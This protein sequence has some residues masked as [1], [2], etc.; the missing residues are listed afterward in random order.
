MTEIPY[1]YQCPSCSSMVTFTS[2]HITVQVCACGTVLNRMA[3]GAIIPRPFPVIA[4]K[5]SVIAPGTTGQWKGK[6]FTVSGRFRIWTAETVFNYWTIIFQDETAAYLMEGYGMYA[7]L[8]PVATPPELAQDAIKQLQPGSKKLL[9]KDEY[10]LLRKDQC[11]K[12]DV[13]GSLFIPE[14]NSTFTT[15]DFSSP[16]G[17]VLHIIEYWSKVQPAFEVYYT[18]FTS[19][20]L[21]QTR[22]YENPGWQFKCTCG[23]NIHVATFPYAQ[24]C[25]CRNCG[26]RYVYE[27]YLEFVRQGKNNTHVQPAI[28][29]G[30]TGIIKGI[31]YKVIGFIV[32]E[33]RNQYMSQW[34]EYTLFNE[35]EGYAFLSEYDGHWIYLREQGKTPVP[36]NMN[37][38][39]FSYDG[40][41]FD[42]FN[43]Y[44]YNIV[45]ARGEFPGNA[46]NDGKVKCWEFISPPVMWVREASPNEGVVWFKGWHVDAD[47]LKKALGDAII[48]PTQVGV[49]AIQPNGYIDLMILLRNTLIAIGVLILLHLAI[50][51]GSTERQLFLN[52]FYFPDSS[53][54]STAVINDIHLE[55]E[56]SNVMLDFSAPV[57]NSWMELEATLV[58]TKTGTEYSVSKG[59][60][61]YTGV[62]DGYRWSEGNQNASF[63]INEVPRGDYTMK[64]E[65]TREMT[66]YPFKSYTISAHY[67]V[68]NTRNLF[69]CIGLLLLWPI[70]KYFSTYYSERQRWSNSPYSTFITSEE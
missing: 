18:D 15:F 49:G 28:A 17:Q 38:S 26:N 70:F 8:L 30:A 63:Y 6:T 40:Y 53:K 29:L 59:V 21:E 27:N 68:P 37:T 12:W 61:Y 20:V 7:I 39:G 5:A 34:R 54:V 43:S 1:T 11:K 50:T 13:E 55:K 66:Y 69:I 2:R 3:D 48:R 45:T 57:E 41:S 32:K 33:E 46:F 23:C 67:D 60:E 16:K 52:E 64:L 10:T 62:E 22:A 51:S 35:Q 4:E 65:A 44:N 25:A 58:N 56:Q 42:L 36:E 9:N 47:D 31:S 19:L 14:C 24:S